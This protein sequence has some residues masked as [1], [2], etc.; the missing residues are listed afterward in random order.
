[1]E[2]LQ[3]RA[4]ASSNYYALG[5]PLQK[6][7]LYNLA[8]PFCYL[9]EVLNLGFTH[10]IL[11]TFYNIYRFMSADIIFCPSLI[12]M[13]DQNCFLFCR[14]LESSNHHTSWRGTTWVERSALSVW[15]EETQ[16]LIS[17]GSRMAW[18]SIHTQDMIMLGSVCI[19]RVQRGSE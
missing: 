3:I 7:T 6:K 17:P 19:F 16:D 13:T 9:I 1:M 10:T 5:R 11:P 18:S 12:C 4:R 15:P 8:G 14:E 2:P